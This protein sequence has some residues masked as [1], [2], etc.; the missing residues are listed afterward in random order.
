MVNR[1][2]NHGKWK[3]LGGNGQTFTE[4]RKILWKIGKNSRKTERIHPKSVKIE[5]NHGKK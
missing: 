2:K 1:E 4:N 3:I 5:K